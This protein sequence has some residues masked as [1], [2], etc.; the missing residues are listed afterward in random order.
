MTGR[1][2][3]EIQLTLGLTHVTFIR[4]FA[5]YQLF[6]TLVI[7]ISPMPVSASLLFGLSFASSLLAFANILESNPGIV[8]LCTTV[9]FAGL[10]AATY[11]PSF[12]DKFDSQI[13]GMNEPSLIQ[14]HTGDLKA[15]KIQFF[16]KGQP[17]VWYLT[18]PE[19]TYE[20][21]DH[22]GN[23]DI[24]QK[25]LQ[26]ITL[27][28]VRKLITDEKLLSPRNLYRSSTATASESVN[29]NHRQTQTQV[30][31]PPQQWT[32]TMPANGDSAHVGTRPGYAISYAGSDFS[33]HCVYRDG[34]EGIAGDRERPCKDGPMQYQYV[35]DTSGKANS[36]TYEFVRPK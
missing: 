2:L 24:Y 30:Q 6:L 10:L 25:E 1:P 27:E 33:V 34:S 23:H 11:F 7:W 22:A 12:R 18:T 19:G 4:C 32:L 15:G 17:K 29:D 28:I 14:V 9:I 20:L 16:L 5:I 21:F 31:Q 35:H 3:R 26:P 8:R 36:V 13:I